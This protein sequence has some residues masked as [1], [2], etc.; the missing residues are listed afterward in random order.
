MK[1]GIFVVWLCLKGY[2]GTGVKGGILCKKRP[3]WSKRDPIWANSMKSG[4]K[5]N[6]IREKKKFNHSLV[7]VAITI[8]VVDNWAKA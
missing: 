2:V 3:I 5:C 8:L 1:W 4:Q 6:R 7:D